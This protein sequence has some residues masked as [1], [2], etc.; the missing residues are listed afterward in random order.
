MSSENN[1]VNILGTPVE[2]NYI[3]I[4]LVAV[5]VI[6]FIIW[7]INVNKKTATKSE[8]LTVVSNPIKRFC[9]NCGDL[10]IN[11]CSTCSNC[12]Y[13]YGI[14]GVGEC[15]PGG[16][17]G[18]L[19]SSDRD[20]CSMYAYNGSS[21]SNVY[22]DGVYRCDD[23]YN[24]WYGRPYDHRDGHRDGRNYYRDGHRDDHRDGRRDGHRDGHRDGYQGGNRG[25]NRSGRDSS[26]G[27]R[28]GSSKK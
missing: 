3:M 10:G 19:Y 4:F 9:S 26:H 22:Y 6:V 5:A 7:A 14:N 17:N 24:R 2:T 18:P 15:V 11:Q 13:C 28:G 1:K 23:W 25:D 27:S 21:Y 16:P 20:D 12:G 8:N